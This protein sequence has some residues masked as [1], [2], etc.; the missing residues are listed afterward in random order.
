[1][2]EMNLIELL[3]IQSVFN[4]ETSVEIMELIKLQPSPKMFFKSFLELDLANMLQI[5][6]F[7]SR[8][9]KQLLDHLNEEDIDPMYPMFYKMQQKTLDGKWD[10]LTPIDIALEN[11]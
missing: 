9:V 7:E 10:L 3:L 4:C 2:Q 11:N 5:L 8:V 1:M 6:S